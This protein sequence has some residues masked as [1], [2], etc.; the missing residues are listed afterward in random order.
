MVTKQKQQSSLVGPMY[1]S[2]Y[3]CGPLKLSMVIIFKTEVVEEI[4]PGQNFQVV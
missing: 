2:M 1:F 4:C 3:F